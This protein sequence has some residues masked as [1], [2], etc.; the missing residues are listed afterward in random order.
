MQPTGPRAALGG[1][2]SRSDPRWQQLSDTQW[3]PE[4]LLGWTYLLGLLCLDPLPIC[5]W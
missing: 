3:P 5:W 2:K 1:S 4:L